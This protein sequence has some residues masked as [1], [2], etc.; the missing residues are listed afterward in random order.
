[1]TQ[2]SLI[3][4]ELVFNILLQE[5]ENRSASPEKQLDKETG[6]GGE[7]TQFSSL[8]KTLKHP[9]KIGRTMSDNL[10][11]PLAFIGKSNIKL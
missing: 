9:S 11:V 2:R 5:K 10:S 7:G 6:K 1:M 8:Y 4:T 3:I